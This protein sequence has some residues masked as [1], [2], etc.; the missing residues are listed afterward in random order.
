MS[1]LLQTV[2]P[3]AVTFLVGRRVPY[4]LPARC[5]LVVPTRLMGFGD[6]VRWPKP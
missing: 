5:W 3:G 1:N 6:F 2:I 4:C